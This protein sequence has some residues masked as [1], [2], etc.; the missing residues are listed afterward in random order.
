MLVRKS[1]CILTY[2]CLAGHP[3]SR[4]EQQT[5]AEWGA[6]HADRMVQNVLPDNAPD[7]LNAYVF[8]ITNLAAVRKGARPIVN[9]LG[10]YV[11]RK[12]RIKEVRMHA[13]TPCLRI[14]TA[15]RRA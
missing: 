1:L 2:A 4:Q 8:N 11:F 15:R 13:R 5:F 7:I 6:R 12:W 3:A 10:P 9:E 14:C